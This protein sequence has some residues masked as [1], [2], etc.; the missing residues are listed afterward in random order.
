MESPL[1]IMDLIEPYMQAQIQ[2][3]PIEFLL[4]NLY[5]QVITHGVLKN[6]ELLHLKLKVVNQLYIQLYIDSVVSILMNQSTIKK[7][8]LD[9]H[10]DLCQMLLVHHYSLE[11]FQ[12]DL[13]TFL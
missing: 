4:E 8:I 13:D 5:K 2:L 10:S 11:L 6:L 1:V 3:I 9:Y 7:I 12:Q